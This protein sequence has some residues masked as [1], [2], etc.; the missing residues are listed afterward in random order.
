MHFNFKK[1]PEAV[2]KAGGY[3]RIVNGSFIRKVGPDRFH[4]WIK[5]RTLIDIHYDIYVDGGKSHFAPHLPVTITEEFKRLQAIE[6]KIY[7]KQEKSEKQKLH[8]ERQA[9][10]Q[11]TKKER[12]LQK[13]LAKRHIYYPNEQKV[14][15]AQA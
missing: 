1:K 2:L 7:E 3:K 14:D 5:S 12:Q 10:E 15:V 6:S 4:V 9:K 13:E 11:A 8:E